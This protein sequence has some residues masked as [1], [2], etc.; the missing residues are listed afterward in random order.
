MKINITSKN[1]IQNPLDN[2][3]N[4]YS[5]EGAFNE[6][7]FDADTEQG[8]YL[9]MQ[10]NNFMNIMNIFEERNI[11]FEYIWI[12]VFIND[13]GNKSINFVLQSIKNENI[14]FFWHKYASASPGSGHNSIY[15]TNNENIVKQQLTKWL[16]VNVH[17]EI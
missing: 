10:K 7:V 6:N 11:Y 12:G 16:E 9:K 15:T 8:V 3:N 2:I 17:F 14:T 4:I 13:I 1:K 5:Y